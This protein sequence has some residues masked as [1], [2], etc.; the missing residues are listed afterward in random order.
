M[1]YPSLFINSTVAALSLAPVFIHCHTTFSFYLFSIQWDPHYFRTVFT[2]SF[3]TPSE[4]SS[5]DH[6]ILNNHPIFL[7]SPLLFFPFLSFPGFLPP[8]SFVFCSLQV[9]FPTERNSF[10]FLSRP[11]FKHIFECLALLPPRFINE[12][13]AEKGVTSVFLIRILPSSALLSV[14]T[15]YY[16]Q[17]LPPLMLQKVL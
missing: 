15:V 6:F 13:V 10:R 7:S 2:F 8:L 14:H 4:A 1:S 9:F 3:L 5:C 12:W 11:Y 17:L 16:P